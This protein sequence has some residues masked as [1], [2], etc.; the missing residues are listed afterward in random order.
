MM[1]FFFGKM[2]FFQFHWTTTLNWTWF[3]D[4]FTIFLHHDTLWL[5]KADVNTGAQSDIDAMKE[6]N[7]FS[8]NLQCHFLV[9]IGPLTSYD[10]RGCVKF[11]NRKSTGKKKNHGKTFISFIY[12]ST[13]WRNEENDGERRAGEHASK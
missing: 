11:C 1:S 2:N 7:G 5:E 9:R 8:A 12:V 10:W 6:H 4:I 13:T 3:N